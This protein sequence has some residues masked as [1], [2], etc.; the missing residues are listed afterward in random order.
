ME[1]KNSFQT[2]GSGCTSVKVILEKTS[3]GDLHV[4]QSRG[5]LICGMIRRKRTKCADIISLQAF[6]H[7]FF[8][9]LC[10]PLLIQIIWMSSRLAYDLFDFHNIFPA[11]FRISPQTTWKLKREAFK[12]QPRMDKNTALFEEIKLPSV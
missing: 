11:V 10:H 8:N 1:G 5:R 4:L 3:W 12:K 7:W 6:F 2:S 9:A